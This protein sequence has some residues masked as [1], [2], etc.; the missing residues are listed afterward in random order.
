MIPPLVVIASFAILGVWLES[1]NGRRGGFLDEL[2]T[3]AP[4]AVVGAL[5]ELVHRAAA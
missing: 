1:I 3:P 2:L 5:Y 4:L